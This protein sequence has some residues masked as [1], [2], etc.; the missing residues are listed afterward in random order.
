MSSIWKVIMSC[1]RWEVLNILPPSGKGSWQPDGQPTLPRH[2]VSYMNFAHLS[3]IEQR[4]NKR[5]LP[6]SKTS[7]DG[8]IQRT[9]WSTG[10][11]LTDIRS[12]FGTDGIMQKASFG[13]GASS[14]QRSRVEFASSETGSTHACW[15][16]SISWKQCLVAV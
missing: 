11:D 12:S 2:P 8:P 10:S 3:G 7:S 4:R 5:F 6:C 9:I 1:R 13:H 16:P 15:A 14:Q